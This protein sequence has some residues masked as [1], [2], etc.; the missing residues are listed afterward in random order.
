[1]FYQPKWVGKLQIMQKYISYKNYCQ[2]FFS[3]RA[4]KKNSSELLLTI[5]LFFALES[6][7]KFPFF[8]ILWN[9][10]ERPSKASPKAVGLFTMGPSNFEFACTNNFHKIIFDRDFS[11]HLLSIFYLDSFI[12]FLFRLSFPF[13]VWTLISLFSLDFYV[14]PFL[15]GLQFQFSFSSISVPISVSTSVLLF[16]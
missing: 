6:G 10:L 9:C 2:L 11:T 13:T 14:F 1:M 5:F 12:P 15:F 7:R 4:R 8:G 3:H 16:I